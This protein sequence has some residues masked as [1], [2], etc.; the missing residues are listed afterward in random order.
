MF[1]TFTGGAI[2]QVRRRNLKFVVGVDFLKNGTSTQT[3]RRASSV[4]DSQIT[5]KV[6]S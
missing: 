5:D 6:L 2:R 4:H 1:T 3:F